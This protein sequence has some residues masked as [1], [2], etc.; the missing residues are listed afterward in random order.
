MRRRVDGAV[1]AVVGN[2]SGATSGKSKRSCSSS[3]INRL[4]KETLNLRG[5]AE[6]SILSM[7]QETAAM[8]DVKPAYVG[9]GSKPVKLKASK[10]FPVGAQKRTSDLRV[11]EF[12]A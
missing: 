7:W 8:R 2:S 5:V 4:R 1:P 3:E 6:L 11:D 9:S 12:T 10:C